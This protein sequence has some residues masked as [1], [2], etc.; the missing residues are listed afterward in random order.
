MF[1]GAAWGME[2]GRGARRYR[3]V[4]GL[5]EIGTSRGRFRTVLNELGPL[6]LEMGSTPRAEPLSVAASPEWDALLA[7]G[8]LEDAGRNESVALTFYKWGDPILGLAGAYGCLAHGEVEHLAVVLRNLEN[9]LGDN[10]ASPELPDQD[11]PDLAVL[12]GAL[13]RHL[14]TSP[15]RDQEALS[16]GCERARMVP[17]LRWGVVFGQLAAEH[18]GMPALARAL[19]DTRGAA[20]AGVDLDPVEGRNGGVMSTTW[21]PGGLD[22]AH[23][24]P[25][26][27][28]KRATTA[29]TSSTGTEIRCPVGAAHARVP[30]ASPRTSSV[31]AERAGRGLPRGRPVDRRSR[32]Q[33]VDGE[34]RHRAVRTP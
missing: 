28:V 7:A 8:R 11:L 1:T 16:S 33:P 27:R 14:G 4:A 21:S 26:G 13:D 25:S 20:R 30:W 5:V 12:H 32:R 17:V 19:A 9:L 31:F 10:H 6:A 18:Y 22:G 34:E 23:L 3:A 2:G 24:R 29:T 15:R